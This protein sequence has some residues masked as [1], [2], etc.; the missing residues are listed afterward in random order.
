MTRSGRNA[1]FYFPLTE[2]DL[3]SSFARMG[4]G[5]VVSEKDILRW[6]RKYG[7]LKKKDESKLPS[8]I[9]PDDEE[10]DELRDQYPFGLPEDEHKKK[11][12]T[13]RTKGQKKA[14]ELNQDAMP[15]QDFRAEIDNA[16]SAS[17]L[18]SYLSQGGVEGIQSLKCRILDLRDRHIR[19]IET[20]SEIDRDLAAR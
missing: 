16:Y 13:L 17:L 20:L 12:R 18:Y 15:L 5:I 8:F 9:G 14:I 2:P 19:K 3:F 11:S 4:R 7:L 10:A 1:T 6:V